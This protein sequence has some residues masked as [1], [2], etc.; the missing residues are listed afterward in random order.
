MLGPGRAARAGASSAAPV[1]EGQGS[2]G[3]GAETWLSGAVSD[4][5]CDG[6]EGLAATWISRLSG[7]GVFAL[8]RGNKAQ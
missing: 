7:E 4:R 1:E 6:G 5:E 3:Y 8:V 2:K